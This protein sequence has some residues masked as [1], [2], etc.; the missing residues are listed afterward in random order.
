MK[1]NS[2][3][4]LLVLAA[5]ALV[6][7]TFTAVA[8]TKENGFSVSAAEDANAIWK[9]YAAVAPDP[10]K[11]QYGSKEFWASC[12]EPGTHLFEAPAKYGRIDEGGDFS[13]TSYFK[14]LTP[15]DDRYVPYEYTVTF[16]SNGA[17]A[18]DPVTVGYGKTLTAP[19]TPTRAEDAYYKAYT[20]DA[21]YVNGK[22]FDFTK[23]TITESVTLTA[24][25]KY[26]DKKF[27]EIKLTKADM[28]FGANSEYIPL[29]TMNS[30]VY[31][32]TEEQKA[33]FI[34]KFGTNA[35]PKGLIFRNRDTSVGTGTS[36][37]TV[38]LAKI[39]FK[40]KL[41]GVGKI[42]TM[43]MG[44]HTDQ[45]A[46]S[47]RGKK[48]FTTGACDAA[49]AGMDVYFYLSNDIVKAQFV[50]RT[51]LKS[52]DIYSCLENS[53]DLTEDEA[54]G[55]TGLSF[56][57]FAN[58]YY[59]YYWFGNPRIVTSEYNFL[60]FSGKEH[61]TVE[62]GVLKTREERDAE[63][64]FPNKQWN[65]TVALTFDGIGIAGNST[66]APAKV[67]YQAIDFNSLFAKGLGVRFVIGMWNGS[68][69]LSFAG[70][71]FGANGLAPTDGE[72]SWSNPVFHTPET[73]VN[74][75]QNFQVEIT[76]VG[77]RVLNHF[78]NKEYMIALTA[79]QLSGKEGLTFDACK[80]SNG[81]FVYLSNMKAFHA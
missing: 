17:A 9:H 28:T 6:G 20:F 2:K 55:V 19:V 81:R 32:K 69:H 62:N 74:T 23:D 5:V 13:Q 22:A 53:F 67:H 26:G 27:D 54:T 56:E 39:N 3:K 25:W 18:I 38:S 72:H 30:V 40:E 43:E 21:W 73:I 34:Q 77:M 58:T 48:L 47:Y 31:G 78:E 1:I 68:E 45:C 75:W 63:G 16:D 79:D 4:T 42:M 60:D 59:R 11:K 14:K 33:E 52:G 10:D 70:Q 49:L 7:G 36:S 8:L 65:N 44:G 46:I 71:D 57:F 66:S 15:E 24:G 80:V 41:A 37:T 50:G 61:V 35:Q 76:K 29:D 51:Q 64:G 12:T